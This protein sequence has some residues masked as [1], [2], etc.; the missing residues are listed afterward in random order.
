[1]DQISPGLQSALASW[2][3]T[4]NMQPIVD[5][6]TPL[7]WTDINIVNADRTLSPRQSRI[8][9]ESTTMRRTCC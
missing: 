8:A 6:I 9:S 2:V 5:K 1:M 4:K 7:I 3:N